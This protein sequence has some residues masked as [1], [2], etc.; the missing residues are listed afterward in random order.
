MTSWY[1]KHIIVHDLQTREKFY[2]I[3][4]K[5]MAVEKEDGKIA[6][7]LFVAKDKQKSELKYL[8]EKQSKHQINDSHLW[9]SIFNRPVLSSFSSLDRV[10]CCFVCLYLAMLFNI[11]YYEKSSS[12]P[13]SQS[14]KM[15]FILFSLTYEQV[16]MISSRFPYNFV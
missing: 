11:L 8:L 2:F 6:R 10:T 16:R 5:W 12:S 9:L 1:L 14:N 4:E 3:C 15:D 7:E 13:L